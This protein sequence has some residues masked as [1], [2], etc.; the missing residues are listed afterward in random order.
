[1]EQQSKSEASLKAIKNLLAFFAILAAIAA[2]AI[3]ILLGVNKHT[4][5]QLKQEETFLENS[6][7]ATTEFQTQVVTKAKE[8]ETRTTELDIREHEL[9]AREADLEIAE[10]DLE[11]REAALT[12]RETEFEKLSGDLLTLL[13]G[14]EPDEVVE[15]IDL[16]EENPKEIIEDVDLDEEDLED[17]P[18]G[19]TEADVEA[20]K[21]DPNVID[22]YIDGDLL[23]EELREDP[24]QS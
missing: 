23:I 5:D 19:W 1:M 21:N 2:I 7:T 3:G 17:E 12:A 10:A 22:A 4:L 6:R 15:D 18:T 13:T 20:A 16:D 14:E 9:K 24:T 11:S 8:V